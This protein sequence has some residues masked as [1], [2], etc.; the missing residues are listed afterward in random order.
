MKVILGK[1]IEMT[2]IFNQKGE[3][4]PATVIEAGPCFVLQVKTKEKDGY[5]AVQIGWQKLKEHKVK[6][7]MKD[8][9]YKYLREFLLFEENEP[10]K[11]EEI[12]VSVFKKGDRIIISGI[13]KGKGFQGAVKRWG[14]SG[15]DATHGVKH[16]HRTLGS[17]GASGPARVFKGKK[18]PG[19]TGG[20]RV[21]LK[22]VEV[23]DVDEKRNFLIV[24]G[25]VPGGRGSLL[26]IREE[27][28]DKKQIQTN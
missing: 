24:K 20:E 2:Q 21:T 8:K 26:E 11:G 17:V 3:V 14:F 23:V 18:M 16:E 5:R 13:S 10:K 4:V 12:K 22:G 1:K 19:R 9:P 25:A 27:V 28:A 6:K 7:S 15:R